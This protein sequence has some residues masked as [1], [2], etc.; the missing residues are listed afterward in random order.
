M[1][2][3]G[4][5]IKDI[6]KAIEINQQRI[7]AYAARSLILVAMSQYPEAIADLEKCMS[8]SKDE[9]QQDEFRNAINELKRLIP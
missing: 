8:L 6:S 1:L 5:A 4:Q 7:D 2:N 9:A 3:P